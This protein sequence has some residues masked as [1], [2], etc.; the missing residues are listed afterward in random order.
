MCDTKVKKTFWDNGSHRQNCAMKNDLTLQEMP[1][2]DSV[3]QECYKKLRVWPKNK[4]PEWVS[5]SPNHINITK[6]L[7]LISCFSLCATLA[8]VPL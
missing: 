6:V 8:N 5:N 1:E 3:C 4:G 7:I 2:S